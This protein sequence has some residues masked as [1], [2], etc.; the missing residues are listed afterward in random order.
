MAA[1]QAAISFGAHGPQLRDRERLRHG[2]PRHR[3]GDRDDPPRR[4]RDDDR[5]RLRGAR[6]RGD[7]RRLRG[8]ARPVDP[9]RR[10]GRRQPAVRQGPRRLRHRRG[11]RDARARGAGPRP[12]R[13]APASWPRCAATAR[14]PTRSHI[15]LP[16]PGG[17]GALRAARRALAEGRHRPVRDRPRQR[18]RHE[19]A[20]R[21]HG[22]A[23]RP[24][25][26]C[27]ASARRRSRITATK[28]AIG[29]TLG[30]AGA[31]RRGRGDPGDARR[32]RA[33]DAQP[34]RP[35][36]RRS[37]TWTCTPLEARQPRRARRARQRVRLRRPELGARPPALGRPDGRPAGRA[38]DVTELVA[39]IDRLEPLLER[40][41]LSELEVEAGGTTLVLRKPVGLSA[42]AARRPAVP[43]TAHAAGAGPRRRGAGGRRT[44]ASQRPARRR[45]AAHRASSTR[46]PSPGA[47]AYVRVGGDGQ[48]RPGHRPDRGDE[49]VQRDQE[50][51]HRRRSGA[52]PP[53]AAR[54]SRPSRR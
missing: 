28:S 45:G 35:R 18:P 53:R 11:R 52:S 20:R 50:R 22:R 48:R 2:R 41:E 47:A 25:A 44:H 15:T 9:Q 8:D 1:G 31:H 29:H 43:A 6:L 54:W 14:P 42:P 37:A 36:S 5:G 26:R 40:S 17:A 12:T 32:L 27:S 30:A 3:R 19:H 46:S 4:R 38:G 23:G 16:A 34:D 39:L 33:A 24:S 13:A 10:P 21:R 51:R 7:R 49:A